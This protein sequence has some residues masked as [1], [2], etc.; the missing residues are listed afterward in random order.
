MLIGYAR[1]WT[2]DQ[3]LDLQR[4][5]LR[6]AGCERIFEDTAGGAGE[7]PVLR[8]AVDHLS[9]RSGALSFGGRE[10]PPLASEGLSRSS[11]RR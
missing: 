6:E 4:D 11:R 8:D 7:R 3:G 5:A 9:F 1:V 2:D 10:G